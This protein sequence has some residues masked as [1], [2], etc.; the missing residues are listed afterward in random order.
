[1]QYTLGLRPVLPGE[2]RRRPLV[3]TSTWRKAE[4][5]TFRCSAHARV[6]PHR[7]ANTLFACPKRSRALT[8]F[9]HALGGR[10]PEAQEVRTRKEHVRGN[11]SVLQRV[12][13]QR[14]RGRGRE[15][16]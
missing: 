11:R 13:E 14:W 8:K 9:R 2:L 5:C 6:L 4:P 10:R 15:E 12:P 3:T 16:V 1:M 7:F